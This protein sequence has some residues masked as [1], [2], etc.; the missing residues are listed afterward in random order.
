MASRTVP[1]PR[2]H[3]I[4]LFDEALRAVAQSVDAAIVARDMR[5]RVEQRRAWTSR[6]IEETLAAVARSRARLR[7]RLLPPPLLGGAG[8]EFHEA[9][10]A[11]L[12]ARTLPRIDAS[13]SA[14]DGSGTRRCVCCDRSIARW[15]PEY[16][17]TLAPRL[18]AH[19]HC[20]LVW[21]AESMSVKWEGD[22][23]D[24]I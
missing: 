5:A 7:R 6:T 13:A 9:I 14:E 4:R 19:G 17:P 8:D 15:Q 23:A 12:A 16:A 11:R 20:F 24:S 2:A 1:R 3:F 22:K 21:V 10:R 18:Y